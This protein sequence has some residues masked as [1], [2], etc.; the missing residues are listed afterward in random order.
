MASRSISLKTIVDD[1]NVSDTFI[2]ENLYEVLN[3]QIISKYNDKLT[4][5]FL[6]A[7]DNKDLFTNIRVNTDTSINNILHEYIEKWISAYINDRENDK[8][9][10]PLKNYG[11]RDEALISRV[12]ASTG[13]SEDVVQLF[14]DGHYLFMS[15]ENMN[16]AILE[17][18]L[19]HVLEPHGWLWCAGAIYRAIDFCYFGENEIVLL[20]VKNKYNTENSSSSAI[21][22]G[23]DIIKW[24]RLNRPRVATGLDRPLPNW[25]KLQE[26]VGIPCINNLL[27]EDSYLDY[28]EKYST[29]NLDTL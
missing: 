1:F 7:I 19:A 3:N 12:R 6:F 8:L 22:I 18:Y 25:K 26:I 27:T 24:N 16:G 20:Q 4:R 29:Q 5:L 2:M 15:A 10:I 9:L 23:T 11:E 17:Q 21:R 13:A 14:I 28:I